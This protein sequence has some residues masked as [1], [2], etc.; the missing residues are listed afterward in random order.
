MKTYSN[1]NPKFIPEFLKIIE[2]APDQKAKLKEFGAIP[3]LNFI[4]AMNFDDRVEFD[5]PNG[6]P[7]E[8]EGR[9]VGHSDLFAPAASSLRRILVC[10]K[11]DPR[12]PRYKKEAVFL[13]LLEGLNPEEA[14]IVVFAKDKALNELYPWLTRELVASSCPSLVYSNTTWLDKTEQ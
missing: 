3:P 6:N 7:P 2:T 13:Q 4:L 10:L 14:K 9:V 1:V 5:L 8:P 11:S 12:L